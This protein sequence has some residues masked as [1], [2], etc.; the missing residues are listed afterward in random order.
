MDSTPATASATI[1]ATILEQIG[2]LRR[3]AA[4][5]GAR[6]FVALEAGAQFGIGRGARDGITKVRIELTPADLYDVTFYR[7]RGA[8]VRIVSEAAGLY[9]DQLRDTFERAT[10]FRLSL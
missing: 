10:G 8:Q 9:A 5:T 6:D 7:I 3:L 1:A 4:M 2:G